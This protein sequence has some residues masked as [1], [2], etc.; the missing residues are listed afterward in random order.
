MCSVALTKYTC[1]RVRSAP[2]LAFNDATRADLRVSSWL[3][4][5]PTRQPPSSPPE[6]GYAHLQS[7]VPVVAVLGAD[8]LGTGTVSI[9]ELEQCLV[10]LGGW[11]LSGAHVFWAQPMIVCDCF[12]FVERALANRHLGRV[13]RVVV[14]GC[15]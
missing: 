2:A 1:L 9:C 5:V 15:A 13:P 10:L 12:V 11:L 14:G 3:S 7:L 8:R 4:C 6:C